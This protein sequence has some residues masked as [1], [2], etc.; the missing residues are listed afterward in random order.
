[1][2]K[3][4]IYLAIALVI[5]AFIFTNSIQTADTSSEL[6]GGLLEAVN[7]VLAR[8]HLSVSHH[9]LR[10][11]AHFS[12]FFAQSVFLSLFFAGGRNKLSA[13]AVYTAFCGLFSACCDE[14]IQLFSAGR[15]SQVSDVFI[16]FS[17]TLAALALIFA[18]IFLKRRKTH[19]NP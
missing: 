10:K 4:N 13:C 3:R 5:T 7:A 18:V 2:K 17:G 1:M 6:S 8:I 16:D 9:F 14:F 15:G 12:E 11:A 19:A